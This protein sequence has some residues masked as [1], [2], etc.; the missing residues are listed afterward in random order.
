[1]SKLRI[2]VAVPQNLGHVL[3]SDI[4]ATLSLPSAPGTPIKADFLTM[5]GAVSAA[6]RTIVTELVVADGQRVL[7]PGAYVDVH[8]T[9]PGAPNILVVP[10]QALLFRAQGMQVATVDGSDAVHLKE[11]IVG[12]DL[13]RTNRNR[14]WPGRP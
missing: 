9:V 13:G 6:T 10:S 2:F 5:A 14:V 8:L 4:K 1:M 11:V 12:D 7:F 3:T